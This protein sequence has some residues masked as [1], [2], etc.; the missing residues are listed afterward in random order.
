MESLL[1]A[2]VSKASAMQR[3][4]RAGRTSAGKCFRIYTQWAFEVSRKGHT[5]LRHGHA[6]P[7]HLVALDG[8]RRARAGGGGGGAGWLAA[9]PP[10]GT[11]VLMLCVWCRAAQNEMPDN[12]VPEIQRTNLGNVVLMLKS[13]GINDLVNFDFMDPPPAE[14]LL[15][16]LEQLYA[17]G[18]LNDR[19]ELT[20]LGRCVR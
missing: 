16:A 14:S 2:P 7:R 19:G 3:A 8:W 5:A 18:A 9:P 13:L 15:R 11:V 10:L 12:T 17:L 20:K 4:G 6:Q 1:V